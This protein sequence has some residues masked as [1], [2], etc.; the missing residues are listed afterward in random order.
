M[1]WRRYESSMIINPTV[2]KAEKADVSKRDLLTAAVCKPRFSTAQEVRPG[3]RVTT[4]QAKLC[5]PQ[6][7]QTG[8]NGCLST[9]A[10]QQLQDVLPPGLCC[11]RCFRFGDQKHPV[12]PGVLEPVPVVTSLHEGVV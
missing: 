9:E 8:T 2:L 11:T 1:R 3:V 10:G 6:P 4:I 12:C 7:G 5:P